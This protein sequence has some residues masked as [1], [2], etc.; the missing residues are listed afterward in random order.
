M[1]KYYSVNLV[2]LILLVRF[3]IDILTNRIL[4]QLN[5]IFIC[6][7]TY[8]IV[9]KMNKK[10]LLFRSMLAA[11]FTATSTSVFSAG[12]QVNGQSATGLGRAFSG[13]AV[14][15]DNASVMARNP[16]AIALFE[17][18]EISLGMISIDSDVIVHSG[19]Y[20]TSS[21]SYSVATEQIGGLSYV[22]NIFYIHPISDKLTLGAGIYSNFGTKTEF[23]DEFI[24]NEFGGLTDLK[25]VNFGLTTSYQITNGLSLGLGLDVVIG[26]G[27]LKRN[28]T[29]LPELKVVDIDA[30][31]VG[32]GG[33]VGLVYQLNDRHRFGLSYRYS[34]DIKASGDIV[35]LNQVIDSKLVL[36]LP[37][38]A[39][40]SGFHQLIDNI[41]IHYSIQY[42]GWSDFD[43]LSTENNAFSKD[44]NW[45]D[46]MHY[47]IGMT[48]QW[49]DKFTVRGGY[50]FDT[51]AQDTITS[52][53][54]PDSNRQWI[55][56]GFSYHY[57]KDATIDFG[58]TYLFGKNT[59][60]DEILAASLP[61]I[62]AVTHADAFMYGFQY[63]YKF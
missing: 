46:G 47:S 48:Y 43:T 24:A 4:C 54:V 25:T 51:S 14:I 60:A 8:W 27:K 39:E 22:P 59:S 40:F 18:P 12:F 38:I 32:L 1:Y 58:L 45:K 34:P 11:T 10:S 29:Q 15:A 36:K 19:I 7:S 63:T 16:A 50:M 44:Y 33:N 9:F 41:A 21:S 20:N 62:Q 23:S 42:I 2:I 5:K 28:F 56:G 57:S 30:K 6:T 49:N 53:S 31:G 17:R 26:T 3:P 61:S 35:Y 13:D 37:D 52:I 55:S